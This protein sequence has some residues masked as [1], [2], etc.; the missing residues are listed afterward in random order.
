MSI[1]VTTLNNGLRIATDPMEGVKTAAVAVFVGAGARHEKEDAHGV[2]HF[3]E[4]MAFKGTSRRSA[5]DIAEEIEAVG[6]HLN[7]Y[8]AREQTTY[9]ARVMQEDVPLGIDIL[10]DIIQNS[11]FAEGEMERERQVILQELGQ[12]EDTPDDLVFDLLQE[13]S[14]P[15]QTLGRPI[16]GTG[17]SVGGMAA[18]QLRHFIGSHYGP[19]NLV[20]TASGA[21]DHDRI[22]EMAARAF[23]ALPAGGASLSDAARFAGGERRDDRDLEQVHVAL[24]FPGVAYGDPDFYAAQVHATIMGGGM[25]S[26]L[27]QEVRE[28]RGL[29]YSVFAFTSSY[30]DGGTFSVYAGTGARDVK[31]LIPVVADELKA[32]TE[33]VTA[34]ELSRARAQ[35]KSG[36]L[37]SL[38]STTA[39]SEQLG[40]QI[41]VHGRPLSTEELIAAVDAVDEA[42]IRRVARRSL[43]GEM[44][45]AALGPIR[46][47]ERHDRIAARFRL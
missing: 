3:L 44:A 31:E 8:T 5:R 22:V 9:Y 26:R 23:D 10:A 46:G 6:G 21:V 24:S 14:Y 20:F 45:V 33:S 36:L 18:D 1:R 25:S 17:D 43:E 2:A 41:L 28:N 12:V 30:F 34:A 11:A 38:E 47:L 29:A 32:V 16:L 37:M 13:V 15:G 40:R 4:H 42:A 19:H 7:A 35:L 39:R 27:F